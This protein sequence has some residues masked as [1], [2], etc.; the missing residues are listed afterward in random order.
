MQFVALT[1]LAIPAAELGRLAVDMTMRQLD[2][3][4]PAEIRLLSPRLTRRHSTARPR[5]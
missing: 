4:A 5:P 1:S 2:G 3:P